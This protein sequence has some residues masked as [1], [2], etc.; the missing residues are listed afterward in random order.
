MANQLTHFDPFGDLARL[1]PFRGMDDLFRD[2][3]IAPR[4]RRDSPT[5]RLD[6]AETDKFY[7]IKAEIPGVKKEDIKVS[8]EGNLVAI[9]AEC[10]REEDGKGEATVHSER[11]WGQLSRRFTL[12]HDV[13]DAKA[14]AKYSDGV[15]ELT[16]PKKAGGSS[17]QLTIH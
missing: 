3:S 13:D 11:F 9:T 2:F 17:R 7:K 15:L 8:V 4:L 10:R 6:V 14:D 12:P 16:L 5:I 1:D